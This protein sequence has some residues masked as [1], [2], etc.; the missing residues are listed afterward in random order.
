ME[1]GREIISM[2]QRYKNIKSDICGAFQ[3]K[4]QPGY[5]EVR[6]VWKTKNNY[7]VS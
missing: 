3:V 6:P 7:H 5:D 1:N 2:K 4:N